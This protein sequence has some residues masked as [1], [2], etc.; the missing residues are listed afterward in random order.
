MS[1]FLTTDPKGVNA[2]LPRLPDESEDPAVAMQWLASGVPI[3]LLLDLA[4][5]DGPDSEII[6]ATEETGSP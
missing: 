2:P 5:P 1:I 3:R 6:A 4:A